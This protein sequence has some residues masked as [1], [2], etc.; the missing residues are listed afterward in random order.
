MIHTSPSSLPYIFPTPRHESNPLLAT[1]SH[2]PCASLIWCPALRRTETPSGSSVPFQG[3]DSPPPPQKLAGPQRTP[4]CRGEIEQRS[5]K[6]SIHQA[7][8]VFWPCPLSTWPSHLLQEVLLDFSST[9]SQTH[10]P[11]STLTTLALG[12]GCRVVPPL[13]S[14]QS[15]VCRTAMKNLLEVLGDRFP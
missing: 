15:L 13:S 5:E 2:P 14:L 3:R 4:R 7:S 10:S 12:W 6:N 8:F 1:N 11:H 9:S